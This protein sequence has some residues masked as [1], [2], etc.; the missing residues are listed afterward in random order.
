MICMIMCQVKVYN[1][2]LNYKSNGRISNDFELFDT[3]KCMVINMKYFMHAI[4]M[5]KFSLCNM[6]FLFNFVM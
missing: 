6:G 2:I 3:L 5:R 1:K 4:K